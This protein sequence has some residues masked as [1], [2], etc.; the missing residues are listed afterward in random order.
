MADYFVQY[1]ESYAVTPRQQ[2]V[3]KEIYDAMQFV[4]DQFMDINGCLPERGEIPERFEKNIEAV[5]HFNVFRQLADDLKMFVEENGVNFILDNPSIDSDG[6]MYINVQND[7]GMTLDPVLHFLSE[8]LRWTDDHTAWT[9]TWSTGCSKPRSG[10]FGG[11]AAVVDLNNVIVEDTWNTL[12]KLGAQLK[13][14]YE[15]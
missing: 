1:S 4:C 9:L 12:D 2:A 5:R 10:A 14:R 13:A 6:V 8:V 11:G 3:A 7:E 15:A